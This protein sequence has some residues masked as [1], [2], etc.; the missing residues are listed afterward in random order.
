MK[1]EK[2]EIRIAGMHCAA[3]AL[4]IEKSLKRAKG[5]LSAN[6]NYA[7]EKAYVEL[8]PSLT[9]PEKVQGVIKKAGYQPLGL[10][11]QPNDREKEA[12]ERE[13]RSLKIKFAFS[14]LLTSVIFLG[15][16]PLGPCLPPESAC[17]PCSGH[18]RPV[19][20]RLHVLP[21]IFLSPEE[22]DH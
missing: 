13:I 14:A 10:E 18:A 20:G 11:G 5:V 8:D 4:N 2:I 6:V 16:V 1:K 19:L 15:V 21:R 17:A 3:C 22:Q 9:T 7:S 12:R